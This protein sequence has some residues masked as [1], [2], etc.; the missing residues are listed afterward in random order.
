MTA[1]GREFKFLDWGSAAG[2]D[3]G[4]TL[5]AIQRSTWTAAAGLLLGVRSTEGMGFAAA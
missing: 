4:A 1:L 5:F 3:D 2:F